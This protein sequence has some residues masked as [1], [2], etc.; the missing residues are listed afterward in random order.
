[1]FPRV[2]GHT[3]HHNWHSLQRRSAPQVLLPAISGLLE[4]E[5]W[6]E[7]AATLQAVQWRPE[8]LA[9]FLTASAAWTAN[10][11]LSRADV[12][13][14]EGAAAAAAEGE[15]PAEAAPKGGASGNATATAD[16]TAEVAPASAAAAA[17]AEVLR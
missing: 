4:G 9:A 7:W 2:C 1:M 11:P 3:G 10:R 13:K 5:E 12:A 17:E 15:G 6:A 16:A 8:D 14:A